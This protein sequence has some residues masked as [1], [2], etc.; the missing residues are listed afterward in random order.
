M[1]VH[2]SIRE[3]FFLQYVESRNQHTTCTDLCLD[4]FLSTEK[5][6]LKHLKLMF[7]E[8]IVISV[9]LSIR[10]LVETCADDVGNVGNLTTILL[11]VC[12]QQII[13]FCCFCKESLAND[14]VNLFC[15]DWNTLTETVD[16]LCEKA[17]ID[18]G[19]IDNV[20]KLKLCNGNSPYLATK[21]SYGFCHAFKVKDVY[22]LLGNS[23]TYLVNHEDNANIFILIEVACKVF[24]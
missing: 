4:Q 15:C 12:L 5:E 16:N 17:T 20:I 23:L 21:S 1:G 3:G 8:W 18:I 14:C 6:V 19:S 7:I 11:I 24:L 10:S 13:S 22:L 9:C 2:I